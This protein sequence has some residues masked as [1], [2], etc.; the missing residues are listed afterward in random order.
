MLLNYSEL[1]YLIS[2]WTTLV[3]YSQWTRLLL[4]APTK[5][6]TATFAF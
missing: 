6:S 4:R 5:N 1:G 2:Q 3:K